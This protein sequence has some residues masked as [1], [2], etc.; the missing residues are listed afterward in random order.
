MQNEMQNQCTKV[1]TFLKEHDVAK[2]MINKTVADV[3][4]LGGKVWWMMNWLML[5]TVCGDL[6]DLG[7]LGNLGNLGHRGR[8][9][10]VGDWGGGYGRYGH[11]LGG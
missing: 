6:R 4:S 7:M 9:E 1:S 11:R 5:W 8:V 10:D 2:L 3:V